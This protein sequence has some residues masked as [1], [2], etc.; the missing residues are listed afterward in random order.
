MNLE[1]GRELLHAAR[2]LRLLSALTPSNAREERES[3]VA[4]FSNGQAR[5]PRW[6]YAPVGDAETGAFFAALTDLTRRVRARAPGDDA[7]LASIYEERLEELAVEA[8]I[9][10][11]RGTVA[12]GALTGA[13][14]DADER[15][16]ARLASSWRDEASN[17]SDSDREE[18]TFATDAPRDDSL[19]SRLRREVGRLRLPCRVEVSPS[20]SALAATGDG[21]VLVAAGRMTTASVVERIV[22]HEVQGHVLPRVRAAALS[23]PIFRLGTARGTDAQEG[24]ALVY[25]E[26]GGHL[27]PRRRRE[28]L[29]RHDAVGWMRGGADFVEVATRLAGAGLSWELAVGLAERIFRGSDGTHPGLGREAVYLPAFCAVRAHLATHPEH[30]AVLASGQVSPRWASALAPLAV[31]AA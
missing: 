10:A 12:L 28:L 15:A 23:E 14:F 9:R 13:R 8:N 19:L 6:T 21:I 4:D 7:R 30:E 29:L 26:R 11:A 18:E 25:E 24:L 16:A 17:L 31:E 20:L 2:S 1:V 5:L 22:A 3:L 27:G